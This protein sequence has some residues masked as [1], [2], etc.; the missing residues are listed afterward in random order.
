MK[1]IHT[2]SYEDIIITK[3]M[4][5]LQWQCH[6]DFPVTIESDNVNGRWYWTG[7]TSAVSSTK[8]VMSW[9]QRDAGSCA[10]PFTWQLKIH[11]HQRCSLCWSH[12]E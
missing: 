11:R 5:S 3:L 7:I 8:W 2:C 10:M 12:H 4:F 9:V 1:M 6:K